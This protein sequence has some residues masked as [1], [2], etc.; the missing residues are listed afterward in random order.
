MNRIFV[1]YN[2]ASSKNSK[3]WTG[4]RL[5]HSKTAMRYIKKTSIYYA[6][7]ASNFRAMTKDYKPLRIGFYFVR[8]SKRKFDYNNVS[9]LPLDLMQKY[10]WIPDDCMDEVIPVFLGYEVNK[11]NPGV[12]ISVE[13]KE[14]IPGI[15]STDYKICDNL[16]K[17]ELKEIIK[18]K[19]KEFNSNGVCEYCHDAT[20]NRKNY[21]YYCSEI[22]L[23]NDNGFYPRYFIS[24]CIKE[25]ITNFKNKIK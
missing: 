9:Q 23:K 24:E 16:T 18:E 22:C 1:P 8:D 11:E 13:L 4:K 2:V 10:N 25:I 19:V 17:K 5:I 15:F 3:V 7:L 14:K 21:I 6:N 20:K 12:Y